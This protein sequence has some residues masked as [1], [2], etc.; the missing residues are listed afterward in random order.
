VGDSSDDILSWNRFT[1]SPPLRGK[2]DGYS[3]KYNSAMLSLKTMFPI[4]ESKKEVVYKSKKKTALI[5]I[6]ESKDD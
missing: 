3:R 1:L 5:C 2:Y 6:W 4:Y